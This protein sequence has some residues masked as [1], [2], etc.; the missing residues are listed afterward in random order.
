MPPI[1][2]IDK[3]DILDVAYNIVLN[4]GINGISAR[5][6]AS[7]LGTSVQ[8]IFTHFA[9]MEELNKE[10]YVKIYNLYQDMMINASKEKDKPY[11]AM[12][13]AY[14]NFAAKYPEFFKLI[15]MQ[16]TNLKA[17]DFIT[18]DSAGN[19]VLEVG[20]YLTGLSSKEQ[21]IFHTKVWIFT[22]GLACLAATKTIKISEEEISQLLEDTV[23]QML[24]GMKEERK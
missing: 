15:F 13:L 3:E 11:K 16:Q 12:G 2:K 22:H 21:E 1:K 24:I 8:P 4:E 6:I 20:A 10:L 17:I 18:A 5:R 7:L 19:K 14:I 23:R 9:S